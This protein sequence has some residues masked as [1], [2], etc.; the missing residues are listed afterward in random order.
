VTSRS[1][2]PRGVPHLFHVFRVISVWRR[3]V[4]DDDFHDVIGMAFHGEPM[5]LLAVTVMGGAK[6]VSLV[7][8]RVFFQD[9]AGVQILHS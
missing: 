3:I 6:W 5:V 1:F 8:P 9:F 7:I 2:V 4:Y